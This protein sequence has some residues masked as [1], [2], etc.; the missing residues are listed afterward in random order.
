MQVRCA[1]TPTGVRL[2]LGTRTFPLRFPGEVWRSFPHRKFFADH[3]AFLKSLHLPQLLGRDEALNFRTSS[4]LFR[5]QIQTTMLNNIPFCADVDG[6]SSGENIR[7]FLALEFTFKDYPTAWPDCRTPL[8]ERAVLNMSFG[9]DSLLTY[10][11]A[12]EIGLAQKLIM[13]IDNDCPIEYRYKL[14]IARRFC[15]EFDE[16]IRLVKNN[17]GVIHRWKY[18]G[19]PRTEWG[20]GHLITEY[21]L[22]ALPFAFHHG[23]SYILLGNEK[24]CDAS[25]VNGE[26][27]KCYPAYDQS[28]EWL[29]ELSKIT[30]ALS[31]NQMSVMSLIEPLHDL[32]ITRIL[33]TRYPEIGKYQMSCFPDENR[34]GKKHYWC[35]HCS[36]CARVYVFMKAS[37]IDPRSVGLD[38]DMFRMQFRDL[39]PVFGLQRKRGKTVGYDA[40]PVGRDEQLYA[41]SLALENGARGVLID[42]FRRTHLKEAKRREAELHDTYF[43]VHGSRTMPAAIAKKVGKIY[44]ESLKR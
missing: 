6:R 10:A 29:L 22:H 3:Y 23:A 25:Y 37:G 11:V 30:R 42:L 43:T 40:T 24:S 21:C 36:K 2:G 41:F 4:P 28:S 34:H 27:Y 13:S 31:H 18:W 9:K 33:H 19:V 7:R 15:R 12:R 26:G 44:A 16:D 38:T 17:T 1:I 14:R 32:A 8:R 5:Q 39:F 20:F 35:G